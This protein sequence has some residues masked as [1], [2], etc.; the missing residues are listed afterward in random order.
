VEQRDLARVLRNWKDECDSATLYDALARIE[1]NP[2][3]S[4]VF[5]KLAESERAHSA[6]WEQRLL[7]D[8]QTVPRFLPSLRTRTMIRLARQFG[9]GFVLPSITTR[10][11]ADHGRYAT[12]EDA[13]AAG[14]TGGERRH[15]AVMRRITAYEDTAPEGA[16][17]ASAGSL[18]NNLRAAVLGANDGLASNFCLM[19]GVAGGGAS[20][21]TILLTGV[22][23]LVAGACSMALGEW[24]SVTNTLEMARSQMDADARELHASAGWKRADLMLIYE[25]NGMPEEEAARTADRVLGH[26][27]DAINTLIHEERVMAA[28]HL[29]NNPASAAAFSFGLFATGACV[30]VLPFFFA[31]SAVAIIASIACSLL[32]LLALGLMTSFFNGRSALFSGVR[33][34]VI[35]AG[36]AAVT[37]AAGRLVGAAVG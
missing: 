12:Q 27:P 2:R 19:M 22:A 14:L 7:S 5:R 18:S 20:G 28:A 32:A 10:E 9:V 4:D 1:R 6:Y 17:K 33:Q 24:L 31:Q 26:D 8:G 34:L 16:P 21:A 11:L 3:L 23:G 30:P 36:A 35:G 37:Y 29:G 15:A 25:A 13:S